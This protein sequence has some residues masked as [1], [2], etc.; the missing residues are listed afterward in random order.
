MHLR[1]W[2]MRRRILYHCAALLGFALA[3]VSPPAVGQQFG[4]WNEPPPVDGDYS[5]DIKAEH[6]AHLPNGQVLVWWFDGGTANL[7][8][9]ADGCFTRVSNDLHNIGC[10]GH[11]AL[12]DG[13][14]LVAGGW[15]R[16]P[17]CGKCANEHLFALRL[18]FR[19]LDSGR[20]HDL[21]PLVSHVHVTA[22]W[23]GVGH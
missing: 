3:A 13:S 2:S 22:R 15:S 6:A 1:S 20:R 7:W 5:W 14:I 16:R 21:R 19:P 17:G 9:P 4:E 10:S 18:P 23:A 12:R 11:A 8:N